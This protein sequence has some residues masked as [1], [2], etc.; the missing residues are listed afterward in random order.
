VP[1]LPGLIAWFKA[2][3]RGPAPA[4]VEPVVEAPPPPEPQPTLF[5]RLLGDEGGHQAL[6][7][8]QRARVLAFF[9]TDSCGRFL[10]LEKHHRRNEHAEIARLLG[11]VRQAIAGG[12]WPAERA[13]IEQGLQRSMEGIDRDDERGLLAGALFQLLGDDPAEMADFAMLYTM[14]RLV[15]HAGPFVDMARKGERAWHEARL[16]FWITRGVHLADPLQVYADEPGAGVPEE[17]IM[18]HGFD[19]TGARPTET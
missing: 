2:R 13:E 6:S 19:R 4:A 12:S 8:A 1:T 5:E 3:F 16:R 10:L 14:L 7:E 18:L 11:L 15:R 9:A 17:A